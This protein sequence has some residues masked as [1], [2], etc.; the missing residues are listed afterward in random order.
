MRRSRRAADDPVIA[1]L[2]VCLLLFGLAVAAL[3]AIWALFAVVAIRLC[4]GI[5]RSIFWLL[6]GGRR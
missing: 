4:I 5:I 1:F 6:F 2:L 3:V